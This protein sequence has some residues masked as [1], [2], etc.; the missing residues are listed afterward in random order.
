M[1]QKAPPRLAAASA[2]L[3]GPGCALP[4]PFGLGDTTASG[5]PATGLDTGIL[6]GRNSRE[7]QVHDIEGMKKL[8][9]QGSTA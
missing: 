6:I 2:V 8:Q 5:L 4:Q 1:L 9:K 7:T 3:A